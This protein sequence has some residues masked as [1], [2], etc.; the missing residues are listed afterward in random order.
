VT[1]TADKAARVRA[2][3]DLHATLL[4]EAA[5]GTGKTAL[6]AGRLTMLLASGSPPAT[7]AAITFTEAAAS[8]LS[9]RVHK[10]VDQMLEGHIPRPLE[11]ALPS[12]LSEAQRARLATARSKLEELTAT[13]IHGFCQTLIN[14]YAVEA[15]IDPGAQVIDQAHAEIVFDTVFDL[16]L[17]RRLTPTMVSD[18]PIAMLS[19][20]DP[21]HVV[22]QLRRL[23][24]FRQD[25]RNAHPISPDL[26]GRPDIDL[27]EA[28]CAFKAWRA[29]A[30]SEPGTDALLAG[31]EALA[32]F[33]QD[34]FKTE[35]RFE[36]LWRLARPPRI[37][38]MRQDSYD[39][40]PPQLKGAWKK[41]AGETEGP[42]LHD[43]ALAHFWRVDGCYR[44]LRGKIATALVWTLSR[45][46]DEVLDAYA[47]F[48]RNAA[49]LDFDDLLYRARDLVKRHENVRVALGER[50][51][52]ILVDEFQDTDPIQAE[53]LFRI[54]A[55][56][57]AENWYEST[58][59]DGALF[60]VGDPKQAIYR[61]RG[62]DIEI[63]ERARNAIRRQHPGNELHITSSFR[64]LPDILA[65]VNR[66]FRDAL[67]AAGQPGYVAL[68]S[69]RKD[70]PHSFPCVAKKTIELPS[71]PRAND[72]RDA[73]ARDVA[74]IC[75]KLIGNVEV[76]AEDGTRRPLVPADIALLAPTGTQLHRYE[77]ALDE[78]G[79]PY[80]SQ[81]GKNLFERQEV[82]D[83]VS[84]AR[85]LAD[86]LDTLAFGALMR[87]PLVGLTEEELLDITAK[88]PTD[89]EKPDLTPRFSLLTNPDQV[90]HPLASQTLTLLRDLWRRHSAT[91]PMLLLS[92]A[93]E[94][95]HVRAILAARDEN[96][97]SRAL[98]N[99]DV[100]LELA[101]AYDIRGLKHFV[102]DLTRDWSQHEPHPEGRVEAAGE[103][104]EIVSIHSSKGL[105]WP[106]VILINTVTQFPSRGEFV[107]RPSDNTLHWVLGDVVPPD[108]NAA[109]D[110]DTESAA[111]ERE[112]LF[113]VAFTRA[114]DLLI[115]PKIPRTNVRAWTAIVED[116][117]QDLPEFDTSKLQRRELRPATESRNE[118]TAELFA[119]Q[120]RTIDDG[121]RH[122][123]W[124]RPSLDDLDRVLTT[125]LLVS[126]AEDTVETL[127]TVGAG[128]TRGLLLHKLMEE[129]LTG[130]LDDELETLA[131]RAS[132]LLSQLATTGS[133]AALPDPHELGATIART[134]ALPEIAT[135]RPGLVA[136]VS[137]FGTLHDADTLSLAARADAL[138]VEDGQPKVVIDWKSDVQP[139]ERDIAF[140]AAQLRTYMRATDAPRGAL[141]YM[142]SGQVHWLAPTLPA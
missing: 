82:H 84:L 81:A 21:T 134:L 15:D 123:T 39:L 4:V 130:E 79:V 65:H 3:T 16:W 52:R 71:T 9:D 51:S 20:E 50:F 19:K 55:R 26:S 11:D 31:L 114:R 57:S 37:P 22:A 124:L 13:T 33:Y 90:S 56:D 77:H 24:R 126:A 141:V 101:R 43:E 25:H 64:S 99:V 66:C 94:R 38:S 14:S 107:H 32:L 140:H 18:D 86:P 97:S 62:A 133:S 29:A 1:E 61:F 112:R 30:P 118:Q 58:L 139:S 41:I 128:R 53:V 8:E 96:R 69:T 10:Y 60:L 54:A 17:R 138:Y 40:I 121:I 23:A 87:G 2:L 75:A 83:L 46:L 34:T 47:K 104:I 12:G 28:V 59:R 74:E 91:S 92:E 89:A 131:L 108:L 137:M 27:V 36:L 5:A 115:L 93:I 35:P 116:P 73:E 42:R 95:L 127:I 119:Q 6:I 102:R 67:S 45:Q 136:E 78:V 63:Y 72:I 100:F 106:V 142:S 68:T 132:E 109:L 80:A 125:E 105:E 120:R 85:T 7:L 88:L 129:V 110:R 113:Y 111:R 70:S 76:T 135:L 98:A 48:K 49:L 122:V 44:A 103:A 117:F